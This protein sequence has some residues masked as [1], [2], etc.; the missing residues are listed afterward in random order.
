MILEQIDNE[1]DNIIALTVDPEQAGTRLDVLAAG[2]DPEMTRSRVQRLIE[3]G[4]VMVNDNLTKSNYKVRLGDVITVNMPDPEPVEIA[5]EDIPLEVIYED[6][7]LLVVNKPQGMVV[8]PATGNYHGTMVNALLWHCRDLSGINGVIRP[9][10]VHRIDKDT[11]GLLVVAKNDRS[12]LSL[13]VQ[14]KEHAVNRKYLAVVHHRIVE[15]GG[16]ID[17]PIGRDARD[18]K[19]MAVT[20]RNAKNAVTKYRVMERFREY[21]LVEC[22]LET[23]RTH[24]IRV[25]MAYLGH[26]VAGDP[27]Y[28]PRKNPLGLAG[29]ALHAF[30]L[31]FQHPG[32]GQMMEFE[33]NP[34]QYFAELVTNLRN[35]D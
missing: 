31:G 33:V 32:S 14:I 25:H 3:T 13:A 5:A 1:L 23:G 12:H 24:Q 27:T 34:P 10:I 11:S 6:S 15:P 20:T 35:G 26:P 21:T 2:I 22:T 4:E 29:Q 17:A 30:H 28:G 16:K 8:H 7:D 18:R 9:G 19:K